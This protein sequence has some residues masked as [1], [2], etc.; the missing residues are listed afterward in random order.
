[1]PSEFALVYRLVYTTDGQ[2]VSPGH[3]WGTAEAI[4][5][6]ANCRVI[7]SSERQVPRA[8]LDVAGFLYEHSYADVRDLRAA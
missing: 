6:L 7:F 8:S 5:S 3:I 1:M 4:S 2:E